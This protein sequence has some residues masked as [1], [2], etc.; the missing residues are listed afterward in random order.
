MIDT[1]ISVV[2]VEDDPAIRQMV[3]ECL[4]SADGFKCIGEYARATAAIAGIRESRPHVVLVDINLAGQS[5]IDCIRALKPDLPETEFIVITV[6]DDTARVFEALTAGAS[7]YLLK[8]TPC[9]E[10]LAAIRQ[11]RAGGSPMSGHIARKVVSW[12]R[13]CPQPPQAPTEN[14]T[15]REK[16]VLRL[17]AQGHSYKEIADVLAISMGTVNTHVRRIYRKLHVQSRMQA[18][19]A[20]NGS[21]PVPP[22]TR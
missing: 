22:E 20:L 17:L 11:V 2:V 18:V 1:T 5:G 13:Q 21:W 7:G 10:V 15:Q 9:G 4:E 19:A 6:Y 16:D 12:F 8:R 14:L 3:A